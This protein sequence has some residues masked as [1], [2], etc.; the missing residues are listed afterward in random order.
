M[1]IKKRDKLLISI[2][3]DFLI[4]N[5]SISIVL[6]VNKT[7]YKTIGNFAHGLSL[8]DSIYYGFEIVHNHKHH[9]IK[10]E[11]SMV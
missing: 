8:H 9:I 3:C 7:L 11:C 2:S 5:D 4:Y 6:K 10:H 1:K